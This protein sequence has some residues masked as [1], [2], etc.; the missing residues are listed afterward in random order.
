MAKKLIATVVIAFSMCTGAF[1]LNP[2]KAVT[3]YIIDSWTTETGLPQSSVLAVLQTSDG[4]LWIGTEEGLV[5]FDGVKFAIFDQDNTPAMT[6]NYIRCLFEDSKKNLWIGTV[7]GGLLIY[8]NGEFKQFPGEKGFSRYSIFAVHED[9][10][11]MNV[12][13]HVGSLN[14]KMDCRTMRYAPSARTVKVISGLAP[15][16]DYVDL[17]II[18][19]FLAAKAMIPKGN[20]SAQSWKIVKKASGLEQLKVFS[21]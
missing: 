19:L 17:K 6:A 2:Q 12:Q 14:K 20:P 7:D 3:Q 18:D 5:R 8:K 15:P 11:G 10:N 16:K 21:N 13:I 4:Y 9:S 1:S